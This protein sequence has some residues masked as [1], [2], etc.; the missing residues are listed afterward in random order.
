MTPPGSAVG[1]SSDSA[2]RSA[3]GLDLVPKPTRLTGPTVDAAARLNR[4]TLIG[5]RATDR[6]KAGQLA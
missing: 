4:L 5:V 6:L 2:L 1:S 3:P